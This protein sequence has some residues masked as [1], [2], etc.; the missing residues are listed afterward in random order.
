MT[1]N[2]MSICFKESD[3][4]VMGRDAVGVRGIRLREGDYVVAGV[5]AIEGRTLLAITENGY[6]KRTEIG[7][8]LR[9]DEP[10][11][12]GGYGLKGYQVTEKTGPI[13]GAKVVSGEEDILLISDDGTIIRMASSD[14]NVYSRAAQGV[15]VMR[16]AENVKVISLARAE[17][18][19]AEGDSILPEEE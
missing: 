16:V 11:S 7:E 13:A 19:A 15:R 8:Y 5:R 4:R 9:G 12:R 10:Q 1:H 6:G 14:V 18:E 17:K 2:G 3:V